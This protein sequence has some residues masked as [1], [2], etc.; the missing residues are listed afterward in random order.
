MNK[1]L[2]I[3]GT[4]DGKKIIHEL[5]QCGHNVSA[6]VTSKLGK[7]IINDLEDDVPVYQGKMNKEKII[8]VINK[9]KPKFIV[10]AA[11][12]FSTEISQN[13][14]TVAENR[15]IMYIRYL[16]EKTKCIGEDIF[17]IKNYEELSEVLHKEEGN[18][19]ITMGS[20]NIEF[21]TK[22][23]DYENRIFLRVLP[24]SRVLTKCEKLGFSPKN[25][26]AMKGPFSEIL[27]Y[28]MFRRCNASVVVTKDSGNIGG[29]LEKINAARQL[30]MKI[31]ILDQIMD[32][33]K[34]KTGKIEEIVDFINLHYS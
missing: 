24:N 26:I 12:P 5:S 16:R 3:A 18:I 34:N 7:G 28:E 25:I 23:K 11:N 32:D 19:F 17:R 20:K 30:G 21:L 22:I 33:Y 8:A 13:V 6:M 2:V 31:V 27:N 14:I 29:V 4:T 10:D 9:E 1:V 15:K